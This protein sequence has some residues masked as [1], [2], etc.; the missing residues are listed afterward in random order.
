M[1]DW[2]GVDVQDWPTL[3]YRD[4]AVRLRRGSDFI[5]ASH[6]PML[7]NSITIVGIGGGAGGHIHLMTRE[8]IAKLG[9]LMDSD[10]L[11]RLA[12]VQLFADRGEGYV[13]RDP[14]R[15]AWRKD[16]E[17]LKKLHGEGNG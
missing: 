4:R 13:P 16:P 8:G 5:C 11:R 2:A 14:E 10:E 17:R 6:D 15:I 7:P 12:T 1:I 9:Y 3:R